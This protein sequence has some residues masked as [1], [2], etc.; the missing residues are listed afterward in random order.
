MT[1]TEIWDNF[2]DFITEYTANELG[3]VSMTSAEQKLLF[4]S[5]YSRFGNSPI[6]S[7]D[8]NRFK[9]NLYSTIYNYA[10]AWLKRLDIQKKLRELTEDD[11]LKGSKQINNFARNPSTEPSTDA[12]TELQTINEQ[13]TVN[14]KRSKLDAYATLWGLLRP[15]VTEEF[16][17][18]FDRLFLKIV[19]PAAPLL[20]GY[21]IED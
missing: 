2:D 9:Y 7:T 17:R 4:Y 19:T 3:V 18:Q 13:S 16:L 11:L 5:L 6:A 8:V 1:F 10:P 20:Y 21:E 12:L 15:D 14:Y